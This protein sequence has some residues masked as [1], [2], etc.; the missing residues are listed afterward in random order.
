MMED[1]VQWL[2]LG[3]G[4]MKSIDEVGR[5]ECCRSETALDTCNSRG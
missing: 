3:I 1:K 4:G 2:L 5:A